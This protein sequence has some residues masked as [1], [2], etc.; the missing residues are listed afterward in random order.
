MRRRSFVFG[1]LAA[2]LVPGLA[3]AHPYHTSSAVADVRKRRLE[4]TLTVRPEDLQEAL[5]RKA[6]RRLHIDSDPEV[7]LLARAYV[8]TRFVLRDSSGPLAMTWVGCEI[9]ADV[10]RLYFAFDL[11]A[12]PAAVTLRSAVFFELAPSQV[13]RVLVRRGEKKRTLRFRSSD[14]PHRLKQ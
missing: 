1:S 14:P 9:S 10:G 8:E 12:D 13:N 4:V 2:M 5:R 3:G 7:D 11:P 6:G